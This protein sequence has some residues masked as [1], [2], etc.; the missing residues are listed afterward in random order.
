MDQ[1]FVACEGLPALFSI[2]VGA[3]ETAVTAIALNGNALDVAFIQSSLDSCTAFVSVD[4]IH[5]P[6][7]VTEVRD[8]KVSI[9]PCACRRHCVIGANI[10]RMY[11]DYRCFQF[12]KMANG[13]R[14][15]RHRGLFDGSPSKEWQR[16]MRANVVERGT[17]RAAMEQA[18][19]RQLIKQRETYST[20]WR[21]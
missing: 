14:M 13:R 15:R 3:G 21:T 6:S 8:E 18:W 7:S 12:S 11:L 10:C 16:A 5:K 19:G 20:M 9:H 1:V 4:N 2:H 17:A